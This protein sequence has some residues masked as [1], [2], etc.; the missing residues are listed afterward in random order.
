MGRSATA[1]SHPNLTRRRPA[2][3]ALRDVTGKSI[4][5]L[6]NP[7]DRVGFNGP[8]LIQSDPAVQVT[9]ISLILRQLLPC[10]HFSPRCLVRE[11]RMTDHTNEIKLFQVL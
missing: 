4:P 10:N 11:N 8:G 3:L 2:E 6:T 9:I 7:A 1:L 5:G